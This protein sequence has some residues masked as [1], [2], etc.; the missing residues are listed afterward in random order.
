MSNKKH[1]NFLIVGAAKAG[2]TSIAKYLEEH[3]EI[4]ISKEKEPFYFVRDS[5]NKIPKEDLM[6]PI[7]EKKFH[8]DSESYFSLFDP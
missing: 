4:F 6:L 3:P 1:P 7:I 2:T 8:T 5:F